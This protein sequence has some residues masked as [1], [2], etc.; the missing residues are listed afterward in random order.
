M[1]VFSEKNIHVNK[2][3]KNILKQGLFEAN[4]CVEG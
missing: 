4:V 1:Y 2:V 3:N